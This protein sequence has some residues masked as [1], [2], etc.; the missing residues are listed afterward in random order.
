MVRHRTAQAGSR[1]LFRRPP[2]SALMWFTAKFVAI[3]ARESGGIAVR[4]ALPGLP[5]NPHRAPAVT[6]RSLPPGSVI[7]IT[8]RT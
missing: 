1:D 2:G 5:P 3:G 8:R 6:L 7:G 4:D